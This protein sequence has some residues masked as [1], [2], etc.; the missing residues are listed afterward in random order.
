M[1]FAFI[2]FFFIYLNGNSQ[3]K[4]Y[5]ISVKADTLNCVDMKGRKQ[6]PWVMRVES[7]RGEIGNEE[8]GV[9]LNNKKEGIWRKFSLMGDLIAVE[10][11]KWGNKHGKNLYFSRMGNIEREENWKSVDPANPY[12]TVNVY[13]V[14]DPSLVVERK[15]IKLEGVSLKHG[16]WKY[17]DPFTGRVESSI[18]YLFDKE[19]MDFD[20]DL[21]PID[22]SKSN[23][24]DSTDKKTVAKPAAVLEFEKKN[25]GKKNIKVRDGR[26]GQ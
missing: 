6:G 11:Y 19:V 1:R 14:N 20:D 8:E 15:V 4:E 3:C 7:V 18:K 21:A 26:T 16:T 23:N 13:D 17:F 5:I 2:F 22:I 10:N 25:A 24:A 12:D 9:Y